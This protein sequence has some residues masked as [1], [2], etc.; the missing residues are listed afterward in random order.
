LVVAGHWAA[1]GLRL[2]PNV[3]LTDS[4]CVWGQRLSAVRL[5]D[6]KVVQVDAQL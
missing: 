4:G 5:Q 2:Y 1:A 6:R 3:I